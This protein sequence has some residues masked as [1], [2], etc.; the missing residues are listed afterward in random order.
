MQVNVQN[1]LTVVTVHHVYSDIL[2]LTSCHVY[3]PETLN[4]IIVHMNKLLDFC[5]SVLRQAA[6]C[7]SRVAVCQHGTV[8][9]P[10][11]LITKD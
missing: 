3:Y 6:L 2:L 8:L 1:I 4:R 10:P 11:S 9:S 7:V 5:I